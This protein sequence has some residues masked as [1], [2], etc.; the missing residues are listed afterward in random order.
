MGGPAPVE[1]SADCTS[2]G[3]EA[4]VVEL[5][6]SRVAA[7][8]FGLPASSRC[9]LCGIS[10]EAVFAPLP[11]RAMAEIPANRCPACLAELGPRTLDDRRC[12]R[13]GA[14]ATLSLVAPAMA[15][16]SQAAL[17]AALDAWAAREHWPSRAALT[18][19]T[20]CDPDFASL[21]VRIQ[22][23][24]PLE[25][26]ADPF[27]SM[28]V[29]TTGRDPMADA[30]ARP[31]PPVAVMAPSIGR[32]T[33]LTPGPPLSVRNRM[34]EPTPAE[35]SPLPIRFLPTPPAGTRV[36]A[37]MLAAASRPPPPPPPPVSAPPR[38]IVYPLVSVIAA[39]GEIHPAERALIDRFL[40]SEGL[41][42]LAEDEFKVHHPSAVAHLVPAERRDAV[43]QLM[44]E[45]ATVDGMPD[46]SER[47]VIR[48]YAAAW[49][50]PDEKVA[51]WMWGYE[52]PSTGIVRQLWMKLRRFVLAARW[53]DA[54]QETR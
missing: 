25:V 12:A 6:D 33:P 23:G 39:D 14:T 27:A 18:G 42:P 54:E 41:A 48:A 28:G 29:R 35:P 45:T 3:L 10:Q 47:R 32:L 4:G 22:R 53:S 36:P 21:L 31:Q 40:E 44:C 50:V 5:Y 43:V 9:K 46:E 15:L 16:R 13:C 26:V 52:N 20:F 17:E 2:C 38:A 30:L 24:E 49:N 19:A 11:A 34:P 1:L 8:R 7:C 37:E 51:F